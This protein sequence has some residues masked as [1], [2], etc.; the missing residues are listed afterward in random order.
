M[1]RIKKNLV[2]AGAVAC[3]LGMNMVTFAAEIPQEVHEKINPKAVIIRENVPSEEA[4]KDTTYYQGPN[5]GSTAI[6]TRDTSWNVWGASEDAVV[7]GVSGAYPVGYSEHI[8]DGEVLDT[9]HYTR[10]YLS[11]VFKRGDSGRVWER[12]TVRAKGSFCDYGVWD[13]YTHIVK[14]GT[15]E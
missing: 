13:S 15:E 9:W 2:V 14:Y 1:K 7:G 5:Q 12:G 4:M 11:E 3:F 10:T 6:D 8:K